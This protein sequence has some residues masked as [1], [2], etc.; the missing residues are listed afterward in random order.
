MLAA[1]AR[2]RIRISTWRPI[3]LKS[4]CLAAWRCGRATVDARFQ[5]M[6]T[7]PPDVPD[8]ITQIEGTCFP[9]RWGGSGLFVRYY[10]GQ[11]YYNLGFAET[12]TRLQ[13]GVTLQ[14][15]VVLVA[16][17][18]KPSGAKDKRILIGKANTSC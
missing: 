13:F 12:I 9:A 18:I 14:Q 17:V 16:C 5:Y 4:S 7:P 8:V 10:H 1:V 6:T 3:S 2:R 15:Q 11:D